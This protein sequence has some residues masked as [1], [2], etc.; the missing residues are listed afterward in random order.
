MADGGTDNCPEQTARITDDPRRCDKT[1]S[2]APRAGDKKF[3]DPTAES[4]AQDIAADKDPKFPMAARASAG[5][6]VQRKVNLKAPPASF[7]VGLCCKLRTNGTRRRARENPREG[8]GSVCA[9]DQRAGG[10]RAERQKGD[11]EWQA[12]AGTHQISARRRGGAGWRCSRR[13]HRGRD[14]NGSGRRSGLSARMENGRRSSWIDRV[15]RINRTE[16][17]C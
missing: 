9:W 2:V 3:F 13:I 6:N 17:G 4:G 7:G 15:E 14:C 12:E 10:R 16:V 8:A 5:C 1:H 11:G